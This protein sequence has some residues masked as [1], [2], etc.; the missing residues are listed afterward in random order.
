MFLKRSSHRTVAE[1]SA[2]MCLS[3]VSIRQHLCSLERSG[4]IAHKSSIRGIGRPVHQYF[5]TG[6]SD[7]MFPTAYKEF[8]IDMLR[9]IEE[10]DGRA[11]LEQ[12][13]ALRRKSL[14]NS[15]G[16]EL[17]GMEDFHQRIHRFARMLD[18]DGYIVE[19]RRENGSYLLSQYNC[20]LPLV[21]SNYPEA[22]QAELELYRGIFGSSVRR[23][24]SQSA[25]DVSCTYAIDIP[26]V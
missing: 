11:K 3:Q 16:A 23:L 8:S 24:K 17:L 21:A 14:L 22:C 1:L 7:D 19:I 13:F 5:L 9:V 26:P 10:L 6:I 18:D 12:L 25:G 15:R 2:D 20:L 4:I